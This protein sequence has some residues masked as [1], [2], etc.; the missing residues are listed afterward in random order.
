[1]ICLREDLTKSLPNFNDHL[2]LDFPL[3]KILPNYITFMTT[4]IDKK[5]SNLNHYTLVHTRL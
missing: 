1:M 3:S 4:L 2:R 5:F